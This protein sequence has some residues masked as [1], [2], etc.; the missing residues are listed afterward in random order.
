MDESTS[1]PGSSA[2]RDAPSASVNKGFSTV[3]ETP[4]WRALVEKTY[5]YPYSPFDVSLRS[6]Y[7]VSIQSYVVE[8]RLGLFDVLTS[9]PPH[10]YG[11]LRAPHGLSTEECLE[12]AGEIEASK[13]IH[14]LTLALHPLDPTAASASESLGRYVHSRSSTHILELQRSFNDLWK[15]AFDRQQ[16]NRVRRA[17]R[18]G[19]QVRSDA[20]DAALE[21]FQEAY[22]ECAVRWK[23]ADGEPP[24]YFFGLKRFLEP[25]LV[26]WVATVDGKVVAGLMVLNHGD[27]AYFLHEASLVDYWDCCPN[28]LLYATAIE[29]ACDAGMHYCDFLP[30]NRISGI[31]EFKRN[32]G[33]QPRAFN[34]YRF[35]NRWYARVR[36]L[37]HVMGIRG[38]RRASGR[39]AMAEEQ[40]R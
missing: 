4:G 24:G 30:S 14:S 34:I 26:M 23:V 16:R 7:R 1:W 37:A 29:G 17:M 3:F 5:G 38:R 32:F 20:S 8:R 22:R 25:H 33:G 27:T 39:K 31:E 18:A 36:E 15:D 28:N 13:R 19:V 12:L 6:G 21:R 35:T 2:G 10:Y 9:V 11:G 40:G